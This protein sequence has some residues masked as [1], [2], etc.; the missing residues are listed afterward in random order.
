MATMDI[1]PHKTGLFLSRVWV[2]PLAVQLNDHPSPVMGQTSECNDAACNQFRSPNMPASGCSPIIAAFRAP[3]FIRR[4][5]HHC[6]KGWLRVMSA[7]TKMHCLESK[8]QEVKGT[9]L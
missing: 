2:R 8:S 3:I 4:Y 9:L 1:I 7:I 5:F 6:S